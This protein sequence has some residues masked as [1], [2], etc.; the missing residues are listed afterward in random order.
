MKEAFLKDA[1][2]FFWFLPLFLHQ[3]IFFLQ[4]NPTPLNFHQFVKIDLIFLCRS[5]TLDPLYFPIETLF[6]KTAKEKL[7]QTKIFNFNK[8]SS[9]KLN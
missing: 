6:M 4:N 2:K 1:R 9:I 3:L 5:K 7:Q 8:V